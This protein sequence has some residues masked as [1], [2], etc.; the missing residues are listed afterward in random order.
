M[1]CNAPYRHSGLRNTEAL[2]RKI[3]RE[4]PHLDTIAGI[5]PPD[6]NGSTVLGAMKAL[7]AL[8]LVK[9]YQWCFGLDDVLKA[10]STLGPV[11]V[12]P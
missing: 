5:Y 6:D 8:K 4:A 10:L 12:T 11:E 1:I 7:R 2:A 9:G 3:Y